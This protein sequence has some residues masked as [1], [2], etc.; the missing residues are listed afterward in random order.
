MKQKYREL[1]IAQEHSGLKDNLRS[2]MCWTIKGNLNIYHII[3][4][5]MKRSTIQN[6][7]ENKRKY[8]YLSYN[9]PEYET[10]R[11]FIKY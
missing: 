7:L 11:V 5:S 2:I 4:L 10:F 1:S 6:V 9:I 8:K 3:F